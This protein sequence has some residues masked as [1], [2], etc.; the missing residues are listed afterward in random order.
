MAYLFIKEKG[1]VTVLESAEKVIAWVKNGDE[2]PNGFMCEFT[3][4]A[5]GEK[6]PAKIA[7]QTGYIISIQ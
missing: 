7:I 1:Y 4:K 5:I 6:K 2:L 3:L